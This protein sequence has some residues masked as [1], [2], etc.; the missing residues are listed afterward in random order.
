MNILYQTKINNYNDEKLIAKRLSYNKKGLLR[1]QYI[2]K[3]I[4]FFSFGNEKFG[5]ITFRI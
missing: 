2:Y 3:F 1:F 5:N 4:D